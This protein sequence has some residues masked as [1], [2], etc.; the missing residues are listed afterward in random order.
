M[1][2]RDIHKLR[3]SISVGYTSTCTP[4]TSPFTYLYVG[5]RVVSEATQK[6]F[7]VEDKLRAGVHL[8]PGYPVVRVEH[9]LDD[10][11][12]QDLVR[13]LDSN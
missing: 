9:S 11:L 2:G 13:K 1:Q 6:L 12:V 4:S 3:I 5:L 8:E 7:V 10:G